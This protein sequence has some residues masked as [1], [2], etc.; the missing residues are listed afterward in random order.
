MSEASHHSQETRS[1]NANGVSHEATVDEE[2]PSEDD[3]FEG[4]ADRYVCELQTSSVY[5][6]PSNL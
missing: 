4:Q 5:K 1:V 6:I 3:D 2:E